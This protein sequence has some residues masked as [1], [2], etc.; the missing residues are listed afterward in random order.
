MLSHSS[1][2]TLRTLLSGTSQQCGLNSRRLCAA[3]ASRTY[4]VSVYT[5]VLQTRVDNG[6]DAITALNSLQTPH[7]ILEERKKAGLKVNNLANDYLK[8]CLARIGHSVREFRPSAS[9]KPNPPL[10]S[11]FGPA[12]HHSRSRHKGKGKYLFVRGL[13]LS[14]ISQV[15]G[16]PSHGRPVHLPSSRRRARANPNKLCSHIRTA[17]CEVFL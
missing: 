11:R 8:Q 2:V 12:E 4:D 14:A 6:Q 16:F 17:V 7:K 9:T 13:N 5:S 1:S 10:A 3:A 15:T